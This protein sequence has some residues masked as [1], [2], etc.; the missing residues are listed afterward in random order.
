MYFYDV[1][2]KKVGFLD[3]KNVISIL[4]FF[5]RGRRKRITHDFRQKFKISFESAFL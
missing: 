2:S 4:A 1:V 3:Y 5:Q